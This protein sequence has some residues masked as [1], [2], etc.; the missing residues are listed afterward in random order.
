MRTTQQPI[1]MPRPAGGKRVDP[2][3]IVSAVCAS[4]DVAPII[5]NLGDELARMGI[6][7]AIET[8]DTPVLFGWMMGRFSFQGVSDAVA[9]G[10]L[11]AHGTVTY[12]EITG[13][14][15]G[16]ARSCPKLSGFE[17]YRDCRYRKSSCTCANPE[18]VRSCPVPSHDLRNGNL[19]Q[20]AYSL[21]FFLRDACEGD[22]VHFVDQTLAAADCPG[23]PDRVARM[24]A[25]LLAPLKALH[26]AS[27][28]ILSMTFADL[29]MA[30]DPGRPRW[31]EVGSSMIAIDTLVH[32]FLHRTG[33]LQRFKSQH[34][35]GPACYGEYGCAAIID[36]LARQLDARAFDPEFPDYFPRFIQFSIWAFCAQQ[37]QN[38]CNGNRIDDDAR[39][40][41]SYCPVYSACGRI[42]LRTDKIK[43]RPS[44]QTVKAR[45][46]PLS[47]A[48]SDILYQRADPDRGIG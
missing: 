3:A 8:R 12:S 40:S 11:E 45:S 38:I 27:D 19:N 9:A 34:S 33:I 1:K 47:L 2:L 43:T 35:Y 39:C 21:F 7:A 25:A 14:L 42:P 18:L 17:A 22:L 24:R 28:K 4:A 15:G 10:F 36:R 16:S 37:H 46:P 6:R 48:G 32:A 20:L 44:K 31:V 13:A 30:G 5:N 41:Q 29:L 26:G 23:H